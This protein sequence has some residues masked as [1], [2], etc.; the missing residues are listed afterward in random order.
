[1]NTAAHTLTCSLSGFS[2]YGVLGEPVSNSSIISSTS[3]SSSSQSPASSTPGCHDAP[4]LSAPDLFEI[5]AKQKTAT[6][7][8]TPLS[9]TSHYYFSF[10]EKTDAEKHGADVML[11]REGVQ[12]YT[13]N[14]LKPN[15]VYYFKVRG[16]TGCMP[17][18]WSNIMQVKTNSSTYYRYSSTVKTDIASKPKA[19]V[20]VNNEVADKKKISP[21]QETTQKQIYKQAGPI[22]KSQSNKNCFLLWCW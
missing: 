21:T 20:T 17:G 1:M 19:V 11:A 14:L 13:V 22:Q 6:L 10:S 7:F 16:Q 8:F 9:D 2:V 15:T 4:P 5:D 18:P 3:S 12:N